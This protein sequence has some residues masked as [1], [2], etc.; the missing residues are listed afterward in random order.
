MAAALS[1]PPA[2][3]IRSVIT[4][5]CNG[6]LIVALVSDTLA[7]TEKEETATEEGEQGQRGQ[8]GSD[9]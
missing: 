5:V 6:E 2:R 8:R 3:E 4:I 1:T 9:S 7:D